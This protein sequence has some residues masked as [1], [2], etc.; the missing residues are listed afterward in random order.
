MSVKIRK[1]TDAEFKDFYQWSVEHH[2]TELME[3]RGLSREAA[4]EESVKELAEMLPDGLNTKHHH[5]MTIVAEGGNAGFLWTI[6][7]ET[8][9]RKQSFLCDFAVWEQNRRKGY[10]SA[11][12]CLAEKVAAEAG[13][14]ESVLFVR[15]DNSPARAL[16]EKCGYRVLRPKG[17]GKYM[18]KQLI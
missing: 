7:E 16:Y 8:E 17:Y 12:L 14:V 11:A 5:L 13:C 3:E 9:G 1:M 2:V 10:G 4:R 18:I 15:D 6:H